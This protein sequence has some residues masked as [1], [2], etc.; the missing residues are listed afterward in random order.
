MKE[1]RRKIHKT[2]KTET[3][4][5]FDRQINEILGNEPSAEITVHQVV[6]FLAYCTYTYYD[7]EPENIIDV[8]ELK[9][10]VFRCGDC[11]NLDKTGGLWNQKTFPCRKH[12]RKTMTDSRA[13]EWFYQEYDE[14]GVV[15]ET[16]EHT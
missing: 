8:Y 3:P 1:I 14:K 2:I 11:P 12:G 10:Q 15:N 4:E 5:E 9:G 16:E 7:Y 13:C 6:P